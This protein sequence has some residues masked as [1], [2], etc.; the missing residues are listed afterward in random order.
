[1]NI[2]NTLTHRCSLCGQQWI[3]A[4]SC[5]GAIGK[6]GQAGGSQFQPLAVDPA[7]VVRGTDPTLM[8]K[9]DEIIAALK[10]IAAAAETLMAKLDEIIAALNQIAAAAERYRPS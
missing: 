4:H 5:A 8:A 1:M 6:P 7:I 2:T 3:G 9:L 10:K